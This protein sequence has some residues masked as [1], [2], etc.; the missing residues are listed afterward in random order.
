MVPAG[1]IVPFVALENKQVAHFHDANSAKNP[2]IAKL[3][4]TAGT[5]GR[6]ESVYPSLINLRNSDR[7][8]SAMH[9]RSKF[10][11]EPLEASKTGRLARTSKEG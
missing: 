3:G 2:Q 10:C 9:R 8:I 7:K 1:G 11:R 5:R 4:Y 6:D